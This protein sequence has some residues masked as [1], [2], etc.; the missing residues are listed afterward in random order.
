M[1]ARYNH[2]HV[3]RGLKD[4]QRETVD[5]A[6][7]RLYVDEDR[8]SRFLVA[9]EVGLGKTLVARGLIARAIEHLQ[10]HVERIDIVYVC[11]NGDIARQNI[12]RLNVTGQDDFA[13]PPRIT[14]LPQRLH[15][16]NA[17]DPKGRAKVNFVSFT[18]GTSFVT[19]AHAPPV[20]SSAC[21][22]P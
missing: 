10:D 12:A 9:D 17:P 1:R 13:F 2:R 15:E 22:R 14:L 16:L 8:T 5:Y 18:P 4:F 20:K 19:L 3:E 7:R 6:F 21:S 11:S